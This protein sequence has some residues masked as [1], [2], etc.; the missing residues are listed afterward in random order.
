MHSLWVL[1]TS[2]CPRSSAALAQSSHKVLIVPRLGTMLWVAVVRDEQVE[3]AEL[4]TVRNLDQ[5][6]IYATLMHLGALLSS[7]GCIINEAV[8]GCELCSSCSSLQGQLRSALSHM[9]EEFM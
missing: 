6:M 9:R 7:S 2:E 4:P 3:N 5:H 8:P 1:Q